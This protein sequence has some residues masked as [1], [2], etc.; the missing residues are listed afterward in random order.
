MAPTAGRRLLG[1]TAGCGEAEH[2]HGLPRAARAGVPMVTPVSHR[3]TA[4]SIRKGS[5][6]GRS[7]PANDLEGRRRHHRGRCVRPRLAPLADWVPTM[8]L[9]ELIQMHYKEL[10]KPEME[11]ILRRLEEKAKEEYGVEVH[12]TDDRPIPGVQFAYALNL[13]RCIGCRKC[14]EACHHENNHDR[15]THNSYIRVLE[16]QQ[17]SLS[18]EHAEAV[19]DHPGAGEGSYYMPVQCHHATIRRVFVSARSRQRGRS[20]TASSSLITTGASAAG[21]ARRPGPYHARRFIGPSRRSPPRRSTRSRGTCPTG[22]G[23]WV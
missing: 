15:P 18:L 14:A 20:P 12:M 19:Y 5:I 21:T 1:Q 17:G 9:D 13:S 10:S 23:R 3:R 22:F 8:D 4:T 11:A 16:M 7:Q 2:V 6:D